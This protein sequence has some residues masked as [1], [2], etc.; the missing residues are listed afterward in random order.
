M[1]IRPQPPFTGACLC[2][3]VQVT[4]TAAPLL[5]FACHCR[6]CQKFSASAYSL[7]VMFPSDGVH[8]SGELVTGGLGSNGRTH[9]FCK[10]CLNFV[11]SQIDGAEERM[12]LRTSMLN[13]AA[14]FEPFVE[15]MTGKKLPWANVPAT[16]SFPQV[17]TS[18]GELQALMDDF[19]KL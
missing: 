16:H 3:S 19:A 7:S 11:Y 10:S 8:C 13:D 1:T 6:D 12:N 14:S 4:V 9:Y 17:P 18:V 5:T 15:L 2:G